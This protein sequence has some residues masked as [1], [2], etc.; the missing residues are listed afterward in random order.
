M[1]IQNCTCSSPGGHT[2]FHLWAWLPRLAICKA[3]FAL[4]FP[5]AAGERVVGR[6]V[7]GYPGTIPGAVRCYSFLLGC[8]FAAALG[9]LLVVSILLGINV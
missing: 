5:I 9:R 8:R 7:Q 2:L 1:T 6:L 3:C 4:F